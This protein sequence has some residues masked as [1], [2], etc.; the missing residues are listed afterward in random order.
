VFEVTGWPAMKL[1]PLAHLEYFRRTQPELLASSQFAMSNDWLAWRLTGIHKIDYSSA[2]PSELMNRHTRQWHKD[3]LDYYGLKES[4]LPELVPSGTVIGKILPE[5]CHAGITTSTKLVAGSFDHPSAARALGITKPG[6][7]LLSCGTSWVVFQPISEDTPVVPGELYDPY[8]SANGGYG[9]KMYALTAVGVE[10]EAFVKKHYG[11]A[12]DAYEQFNRDPEARPM[13]QEIVR[14]VSQRINQEKPTRI[15]VT[16]GP[17][18][19]AAWRELLTAE[20]PM[21]EFAP[22]RSYTGAAG[23]AMLAT[24]DN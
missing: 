5:Y 24:R 7:I 20:L 14:R 4:Q 23:A 15:V 19:G 17:S 8:Q 10:I 21:I 22:L 12:P 6:E 9:A 2:V 3:Y 13:M 1:F 11:D 18:E 16:G